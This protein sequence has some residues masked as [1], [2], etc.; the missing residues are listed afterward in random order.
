VTLAILALLMAVSALLLWVVFPRGFLPGRLLWVGIHKWAGLALSIGV[1]LHV[2]LHWNWFVQMTR[3]YVSQ[4][5][6]EN[7]R[8]LKKPSLKVRQELRNEARK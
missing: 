5:Q 2:V 1:L 3:R 6:N 8:I 4:L 7:K